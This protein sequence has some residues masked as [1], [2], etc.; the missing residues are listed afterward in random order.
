MGAKC[1]SVYESTSIGMAH[2]RYKNN[3]NLESTNIDF[4]SKLFWFSS[5]RCYLLDLF[6]F[7]SRY[8]CIIDFVFDFVEITFG[9]LVEMLL[10][11]IEIN[12]CVLLF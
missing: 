7:S 3:I 11:L 1:T 5:K 10:E 4:H 6:M 12:K 2:T 9:T 8:V